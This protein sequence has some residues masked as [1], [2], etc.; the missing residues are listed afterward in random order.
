MQK[1]FF[2]IACVFLMLALFSSIARAV[3]K[4]DF[5]QDEIVAIATAEVKAKGFQL[6][7]VQIIYDDG[8]K[9]WDEQIGKITEL[10]DSPNFGIFK[11]GF[12]SNYKTVYFD[13]IDPLPDLWVFIDKDTG[14]VLEVYQM[15]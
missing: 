5:T 6:D 4:K 8:N 15:K 7:E 12:M 11:K 3:E 1:K 14:E 2:I 10:S 9:L 13:F